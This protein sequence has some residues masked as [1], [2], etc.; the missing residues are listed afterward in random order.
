MPSVS[1]PSHPRLY[2]IDA[3]RAIAILMMLQGHFIDTNLAPEF[4][5]RSLWLYDTWAFWRGNTAPVFFTV[6]G[7][8]FVYLLTGR[9][10]ESVLQHPRWRKGLRR[11]LMLIGVGYLLRTNFFT[12]ARL[13]FQTWMFQTDVLHCI[14]VALIVLCGVYALVRQRTAWFALILGVGGVAIFLADPVVAGLDT[15]ALPPAVRHYVNRSHGAIFSP[16]PWLGYA[17]LGGVIGIGLRRYDWEKMR[18]T[19]PIS[20]GILGYVLAYY[21]A[22]SLVK[23]YHFT[24]V[25]L[26]RSVAYNN[27][28]LFRFGYALILVAGCMLVFGRARG[29][30]NW[31]QKTGSETLTIYAAHYVVL[32]GTWFGLGIKHFCVKSLLPLPAALGALL[33][34]LAGIVLAVHI[35]GWRQKFGYYR[36]TNLPRRIVA[37]WR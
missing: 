27:T 33:F 5:D 20:L 18:Y 4:R 7:L 36:L 28:C 11:G 3:L 35:E 15:T 30:P 25:E 19:L 16:L 6:T 24:G 17:F 14:G 32:Y 26:F 31:L 12:L 13:N 9:R 10:T 21:S 23:M 37:A 22:T 34:V 1:S 8:V 2:F 29:L